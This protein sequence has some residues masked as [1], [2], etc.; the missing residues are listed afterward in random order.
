M[1]LLWAKRILWALFLVVFII[2]IILL[3][4]YL[5][6]DNSLKVPAISLLVISV[7]LVLAAFM[8]DGVNTMVY[9]ETAGDEYTLYSKDKIIK[10]LEKRGV[11]FEKGQPKA[12]YLTKIRENDK[13]G[14]KNG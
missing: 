9:S 5:A 1:K 14:E 6:G 8:V 4:I 3:I 13:K 11:D 2:G 7:I 10:L 12:Y